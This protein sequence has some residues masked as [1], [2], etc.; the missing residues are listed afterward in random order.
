MVT[1]RGFLAI[2]NTLSEFRE[3]VLLMAYPATGYK[4]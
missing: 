2:G 3:I 1:F 4:S